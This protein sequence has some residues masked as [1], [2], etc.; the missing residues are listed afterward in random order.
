MVNSAERQ[1][2]ILRADIST[3]LLPEL[4][5]FPTIISDTSD[6]GE[7]GKGGPEGKGGHKGEDSCGGENGK[8]PRSENCG[9]GAV[10]VVRVMGGWEKVV[11]VKVVASLMRF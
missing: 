7:K 8:G 6:Q 9:G 11:E 10:A 3:P 2:K 5:K 4:P 1:T